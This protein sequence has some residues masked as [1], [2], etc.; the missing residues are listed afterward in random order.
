M[1]PEFSK[2][3]AGVFLQGMSSEFPVTSKVIAAIPDAN[4]DYKPDAKSKTAMELA[5]HIASS[6][7]W[8]LEAMAQGSFQIPQPEMPA[9][10][11]TGAQI[12]AWY[13]KEIPAKLPAVEALSGEDL[14]TP[15]DF[16]GAYNL[17]RVLYL[18]FMNNHMIH[19]RGQLTTYLRAMGGKCPS[20]YG[21]S[22]D[23]PFQG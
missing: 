20:I 18:E 3:L 22:A 9:D 15:L 11:T 23:E 6:D 1:T 16:F 17:P 5:W 21:G 10:L 14:A 2:A 8:F 12:A 13:D 19:H 4:H 7:V